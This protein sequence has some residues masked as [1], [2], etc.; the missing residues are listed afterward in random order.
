[1][2]CEGKSKLRSHTTSY[3]LI[4]VVTKANLTTLYLS[5]AK[6]SMICLNLYIKMRKECR[7]QFTVHKNMDLLLDDFSDLV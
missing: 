3:C 4:E 7:C 1:M 6:N 2:H 5:Y